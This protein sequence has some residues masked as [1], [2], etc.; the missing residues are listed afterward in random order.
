[1]YSNPDMMGLSNKYGQRESQQRYDYM[2]SQD[3][4]PDGGHN[5]DNINQNLLSH[6]IINI[7]S[8]NVYQD[9]NYYSQHQPKSGDVYGGLPE[10]QDTMAGLSDIK[11]NTITNGS[12]IN[13][14]HMEGTINSLVDVM[15]QIR[16][17]QGREI[18]LIERERMYMAD[19]LSQQH[20]GQNKVG[21]SEE[22]TNMPHYNPSYY[23]SGNQT[24]YFNSDA[25]IRNNHYPSPPQ[26]RIFENEFTKEAEIVSRL[27]SNK[28]RNQIAS[29]ENIGSDEIIDDPEELSPQKNK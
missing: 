16:N 5:Y 2:D 29:K 25:D 24:A 3:A 20:K 10:G 26:K 12:E 6:G 22:K 27:D 21:N 7:K 4:H 18:H 15:S 13:P 11:G 17:E 1:M 9:E 28:D 14:T 23:S 19:P 8:D